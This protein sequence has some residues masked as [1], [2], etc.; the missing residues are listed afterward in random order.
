MQGYK[1]IRGAA[2]LIITM[3]LMSVITL[4][5]I[6]AGYNSVAR[7]QLVSN[8]LVKKQAFAAA[9]AG[10]N[11]GIAYLTSNY[12]TITATPSSGMINYTATNL[13]NISLNNGS[14]YTISYSNPIIN[15]YSII[16]VNATGVAADNATSVTMQQQI[17]LGS[18]LMGNVNSPLITQGDITLS[19][20][21]LIQNTE[22]NNTIISGG[23]V[24]I[25]GSAKTVIASGTSSNSGSIKTDIT[26]NDAVLAN[27]NQTGLFAKFFGSTS[28][29]IQSQVQN[30]YSNSGSNYNYSST[31]SGKKNTTIWIDQPNGT[32]TI[33]GNTT[34]GT[35]S[36]PVLLIVNGNVNFSGNITIYGYVFVFGTNTIDSITGSVDIHGA[37]T[38]AGDLRVS[39]NTTLTYDS[40][41][42]NN[43]RN[44]P[45]MRYYAKV[46]GSWRDF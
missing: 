24:N 36:Q 20:S 40:G 46:P 6:Y 26:T 2:T 43:L 37:I 21:A 17:K 1:R 44:L 35:A 23:S 12:A 41:V 38:T 19:G 4:V 7:Q 5:I 3:F 9:D 31:L 34:I 39:G 10:L 30:Y 15:D 28:T 22:N 16:Q 8:S 33:N 32:A 45:S 11:Y 14:K 29:A 27:M 13:T 25:S 42:L 18:L